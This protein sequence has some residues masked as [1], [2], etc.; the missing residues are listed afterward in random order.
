MPALHRRLPHG[1]REAVS[2]AP[3]TA[4]QQV[5][6]TVQTHR[7]HPLLRCPRPEEADQTRTAG[8]SAEAIWACQHRINWTRRLKRVLNIDMQHCPKGGSGELKIIAAILER[9]VIEKIPTHLGLD[10]QPPPRERA[11]EPGHAKSHLSHAG[12]HK[13]LIPGCNG[14]PQPGRRCSPCRHEAADMRVNLK[15]RPRA[16]SEHGW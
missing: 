12:G 8:V 10:P 1:A 9:P 13:R 11:N 3:A 14:K 6:L 4:S 16:R 15:S 5:E 7:R 2:A